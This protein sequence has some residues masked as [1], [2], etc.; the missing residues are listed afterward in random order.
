MKT[1]FGLTRL[2]KLLAL[3]G[4]VATIGA[5]GGGGSSGSDFV[6]PLEIAG[7]AATGKALDAATVT[8]TCKSGTG[9]AVTAGDGSYR[10]L[11]TSGV[12]PCL[13]TVTKGTVTLRSVAPAA[14]TVNVTPLTDMQ[15][16]YLA[17]Q[18]GTTPALLTTSVNGK[19]ILGDTTAIAAAAS[20]VAT[21]IKTN[22]NIDVGT[23]FRTAPIITTAANQNAADKLLDSLKTAGVTDST[24]AVAAAA[25]TAVTT[26]A[27]K[28]TPYVAPSGAV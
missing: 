28:A 24:G 21:L 9:T 26:T 15:V 10:V 22:Y 2:L 6:N 8:V 4:A 23:D 7:T 12:P 1:E 3:G 16:T 17:T 27:Q 19:A 25:G 14:G 20:A 11:I 13:V 5:C 18:A